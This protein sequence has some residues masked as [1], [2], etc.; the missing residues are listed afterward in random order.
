MREKTARG[1][2]A[3]E[4]VFAALCPEGAPWGAKSGVLTALGGAAACAQCGAARKAP[5]PIAWTPTGA[6]VVLWPAC[7][8]CAGINVEAP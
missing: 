8:D 7:P 2:L 1:G 4:A 6:A 3:Y 5:D